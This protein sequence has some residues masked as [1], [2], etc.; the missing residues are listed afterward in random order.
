MRRLIGNMACMIAL[1]AEAV[2]FVCMIL[3]LFPYRPMYINSERLT[4]GKVVLFVL[5]TAAFVLAC[6]CAFCVVHNLGRRVR[7]SVAPLLGTMVCLAL[8]VLLSALS[9]NGV[10]YKSLKGAAAYDPCSFPEK[11]Q[12]MVD[13]YNGAKGGTV[14]DYAY[15]EQGDCAGEELKVVYDADSF[16]KELR[17]LDEIGFDKEAGQDHL[18]YKWQKFH[19][20]TQIRVET[21]TMQVIY[22][23]YQLPEQ[24]PDFAPHPE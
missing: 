4:F 10:L 24:L 23:R 6:Y 19:S 20:V 8:T 7:E 15:Y 5:A 9:V 13:G 17:R 16:S 3:E 1:C 14:V 12:S 18:L 11:L 21:G 22:G 2:L